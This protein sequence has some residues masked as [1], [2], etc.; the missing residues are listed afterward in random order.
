VLYL[1]VISLICVAAGTTG[2]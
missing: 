1:G 2:P